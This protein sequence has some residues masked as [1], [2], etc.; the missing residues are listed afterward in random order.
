MQR[1]AGA[2]PIALHVTRRAMLQVRC[3]LLSPLDVAHKTGVQLHW[4][5]TPHATPA[6]VWVRATARSA[7]WLMSDAH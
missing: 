7:P 6:G 1:Y 2:H 3:V 5:R 4:Y